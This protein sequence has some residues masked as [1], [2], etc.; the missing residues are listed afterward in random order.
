MGI[1]V[2]FFAQHDMIW[3]GLEMGII[4]PK[5]GSF[6]CRKHDYR[7]FWGPIFSDKAM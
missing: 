6:F 1:Y 3:A 5:N 2:G 7:G 4:I